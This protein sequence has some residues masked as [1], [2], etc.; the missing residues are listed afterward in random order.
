V[1]I[2]LI[3]ILKVL[4]IT[5]WECTK[6]ILT[7][8]WNCLPEFMKLKQVLGYFT[9]EG[10]VALWLGVPTFVI[11]ALVFLVKRTLKLKN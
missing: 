10:I 7:V 1:D 2:I 11:T 9:P 8:L 6:G 4:A 3:E 5:I